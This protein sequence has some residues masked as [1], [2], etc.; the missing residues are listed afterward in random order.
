MA[1]SWLDV[2]ARDIQPAGMQ[3]QISWE[4]SVVHAELAGPVRAP[5]GEIQPSAE[6]LSLRLG[7]VSAAGVSGELAN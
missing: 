7:E 4:A 2:A 1:I 5:H 3:D 6:R